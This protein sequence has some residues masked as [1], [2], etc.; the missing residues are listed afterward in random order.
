MYL[1]YFVGGVNGVGKTT[2]LKAI[3]E[4]RP[5]FLV[6]RLSEHLMKWLGIPGDYDALR[7]LSQEYKRE[8]VPL[9]LERLLEDNQD[10]SIL[11]DTHYLNTINGEITVVT[12]EWLSRFDALV[13]ITAPTVDVIRRI[14]NDPARDRALFKPDETDKYAFIEHYQA[15]TKQ[16]FDRQARDCDV[17]SLVIH[18]RHHNTAMAVTDFL[19][20]HERVLVG[21][22]KAH[23]PA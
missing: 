4:A 13:M 11:V 9:C 20:F 6:L 5:E 2:L 22:Q 23:S 21:A 18:H 8:Q 3:A 17:P 19:H 15:L 1:K 14:D 7:A 10:R 16:E 12:D